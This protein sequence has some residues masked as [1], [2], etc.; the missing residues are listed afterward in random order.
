MDMSVRI[1]CF[2]CANNAGKIERGILA[3][4]VHFSLDS[5]ALHRKGAWSIGKIRF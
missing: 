2:A 4:D 5:A 1:I 3:L